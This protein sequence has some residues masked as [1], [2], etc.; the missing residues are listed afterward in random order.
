MHTVARGESTTQLAFEAGL[1]PETVWLHAKNS[2]LRDKRKN[3]NLLEPGDE[4]FV[5]E[6]RVVHESAGS[7]TK[8]R[9]RRKGIPEELRVQLLDPL[10]EPRNGIEYVLT[11]DNSTVEGQ[12]ERRRWCRI[13]SSM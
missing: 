3:P 12:G 7:E 9:F 10:G 5:P 13:A 8:H 6:K 1:F 11:I 2:S 4:I